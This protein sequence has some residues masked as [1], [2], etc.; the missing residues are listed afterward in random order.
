MSENNSNSQPPSGS[1][2]IITIIP[3][4]TAEL[5]AVQWTGTDDS[6]QAIQ[7]LLWPDSPLRRREYMTIGIYVLTGQ[8]YT[9]YELRFV[10]EGDWVVKEGD[11]LDIVT[12]EM[13]KQRYLIAGADAP[14]EVDDDVTL[15]PP[16]PSLADC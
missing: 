14:K 2:L 5:W 4:Q 1:D 16:A 15:P 6:L 7:R 10:E 12:A 13:F 8:K 9:P 11:R 3:Q